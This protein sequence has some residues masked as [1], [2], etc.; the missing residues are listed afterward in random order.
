MTAEEKYQ[1]I[2]A[3]QSDLI[4]IYNKWHALSQEEKDCIPLQAWRDL[5]TLTR[6]TLGAAK[7]TA[8]NAVN[9]EEFGD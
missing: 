3:A 5:Q 9:A 8:L 2:K 4:A 6:E 7:Y 1:I